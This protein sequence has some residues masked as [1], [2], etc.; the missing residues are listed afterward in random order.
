[1]EVP[2]HSSV[3]RSDILFHPLYVPTQTFKSRHHLPALHDVTPQLAG[4]E[5]H[6]ARENH[7]ENPN[8]PLECLHLSAMDGDLN[9]CC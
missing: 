5:P 1:M 8:G 3:V 4:K 2:A 7:N 6:D 9:H